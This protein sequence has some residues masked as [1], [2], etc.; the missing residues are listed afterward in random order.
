VKEL[1]YAGGK[2]I[3]SDELAEVITDYAQVMAAKGDSGVVE[4]PAVG[5]DGTVGTARLLLGPASQII[6]EPVTVEDHQLDDEAVIK[7]LRARIHSA[8]TQHAQPMDPDDAADEDY[9][10]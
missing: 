5:E 7:D 10:L 3:V 1:I 6:V 9:S 4:I 8:G 2:T